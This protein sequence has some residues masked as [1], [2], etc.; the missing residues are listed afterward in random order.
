MVSATTIATTNPK[1]IIENKDIDIE[2]GNE[3]EE[4]QQDVEVKPCF[5][6]DA[7]TMIPIYIFT[8]M[9]IFIYYGLVVASMVIQI[10]M[11]LA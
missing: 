2:K 7:I 8:L 3:E 1:K 4:I 10:R 6:E 5:G 9:T 11:R